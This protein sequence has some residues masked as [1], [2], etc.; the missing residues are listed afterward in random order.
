MSE[1]YAESTTAIPYV[2]KEFS[3]IEK[4][5][6]EIKEMI[7]IF[8]TK[9]DVDRELLK[10][11]D[12]QISETSKNISVSNSNLDR[13]YTSLSF[14]GATKGLL[15]GSLIGI[16]VAISA[17]IPVILGVVGTGVLG[18]IFGKVMF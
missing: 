10:H 11:I 7:K 2:D 8:G 16:P 15:F 9:L 12:V 5:L 1:F 17:G 14:R 3:N 18:S 4:D 13:I 6:H